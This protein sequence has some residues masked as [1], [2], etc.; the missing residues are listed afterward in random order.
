MRSLA[1]R[2][3]ARAS[4]CFRGSSGGPA[5]WCGRRVLNVTVTSASD[6]S[7]EGLAVTSGRSSVGTLPWLQET[8]GI[9]RPRDY[10]RLLGQGVLYLLHGAPASVRR[11][12]RPDAKL[13]RF[14]SA[15]LRLPDSPASRDAQRLCAQVPAVVNHS[16][17]TYL[18]AVLLGLRDGLRY[19]AE[20]V[21]VASLLHD[22]GFTE[23]QHAT[24][25]RP[26]CL[27]FPAARMA[28]EVGAAAGWDE[29]RCDAIAEAITLHANLY[30]G[31]RYGPEA[32]LLYAGARLDQTGFRFGD[33]HPEDVDRVL[34]RYP[35]EGWKRSCCQMMRN[36]ADG[37]PGSRVSFYTRSLAGNCFIKRA[38]FQ[39]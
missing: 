8:D 29:R 12:V 22:V 27:T 18:W 15:S 23:V 4:R 5:A 9:L 1:R 28:V 14:D 26:C 16:F 3:V 13:A 34:A 19:D 32:Y 37:V 30:V 10:V 25:G 24:D 31:R 38:P 21:Y 36:Q 39:D 6:T 33:L 2:A 20:M 7:G 11:K 17:R 35:R